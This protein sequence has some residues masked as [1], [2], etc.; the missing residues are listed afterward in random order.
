MPIKKRDVAVGIGLFLALVVVGLFLVVLLVGPKISSGAQLVKNYT[1]DQV[2]SAAAT[3]AN[4][5]LNQNKVGNLLSVGKLYPNG[6]PSSDDNTSDAYYLFVSASTGG[7]NL[8]LFNNAATFLQN[9]QV[10]QIDMSKT[11]ITPG[12][13]VVFTPNPN[14]AQTLPSGATQKIL[15]YQP[16][17]AVLD[18]SGQKFI[19]IDPNTVKGTPDP[20][21]GL[22]PLVSANATLVNQFLPGYITS[23]NSPY[24]GA[25]GQPIFDW[26][27]GSNPVTLTSLCITDGASF[28]GVGQDEKT[29]Y[30][31]TFGVALGAGPSGSAALKVNFTNVVEQGTGGQSNPPVYFADP[32]TS[33]TTTSQTGAFFALFAQPES[34]VSAKQGQLGRINLIDSSVVPVTPSSTFIPLNAIT[35]NAINWPEQTLIKQTTYPQAFYGID[36]QYLYSLT[37]SIN[38]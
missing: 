12:Q 3:M 1:I 24:G 16:V 17:I 30:R 2:T 5:T 33:L 35:Q 37:I 20:T 27:S 19:L 22:V 9:Q 7:S 13:V 29:L 36:N 28:Y 32:V 26:S 25:G 10:Y 4:P 34:N 21:S 38:N 15:A 23:S 8:L 6:Q 14:I 31:I 18:T 11:N